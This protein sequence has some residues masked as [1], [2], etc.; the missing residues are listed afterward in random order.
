MIMVSV[1]KLN[2]FEKMN[3]IIKL[4]ISEIYLF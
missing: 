4:G 1:K 3:K 2:S